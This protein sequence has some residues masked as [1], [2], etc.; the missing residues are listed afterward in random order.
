V[1][2]DYNADGNLDVLMVGNSYATEVSTGRYDASIGVYLQGD[3][4]G[5][6]SPI[7]VRKSGFV[8]DKDAKGLST[9]I[10]ADGH[11]LILA[12]VNNDK[13]N[14]QRVSGTKKYFRAA[15]DDSY[16]VVKLKNGKSYRQEFYY[17][18]TYLSQSSRSLELSD[19]MVG[20]EVYNFS[21]RK[22]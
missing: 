14:A 7:D 18:S 12:G 5:N 11:E 1:T 22:K 16:A 8:V 9:L 15:Q 17:G 21:G 2:G 20:F 13:M 3:G 4:K 10:L 6:F 19:E